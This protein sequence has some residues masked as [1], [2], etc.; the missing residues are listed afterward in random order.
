MPQPSLPDPV[1][2][3]TRVVRFPVVCPSA[4]TTVVHLLCKSG[5]TTID[6]DIQLHSLVKVGWHV[7]CVEER[8]TK[9]GGE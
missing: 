8:T 4:T 6:A 3:L 5:T 2:V 7:L 1:Q 9:P